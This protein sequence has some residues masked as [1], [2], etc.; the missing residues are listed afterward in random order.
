[1]CPALTF[2]QRIIGC[3]SCL[4]IG[5]IISLGSTA[6]LVDLVEGQPDDFAIM[7]T[8]GNV[9]GL[10]SSCFLYGITLSSNEKYMVFS[11]EYV[12]VGVL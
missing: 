5:F 6:R 3:F 4:A 8:I 2:Q 12:V 10:C 1:M 11:T 7:Y 9:I